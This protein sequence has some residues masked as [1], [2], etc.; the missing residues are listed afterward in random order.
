MP[1]TT[2][3]QSFM[4]NGS[5]YP[6]RFVSLDTS[7][8]YKVIQS[9][10]NLAILGISQVGTKDP[11]GVS[12]SDGYAA[13]AGD[14]I[15][16]FLAGSRTLLTLPAA[17]CTAGDRLGPDNDGKGVVITPG[18]GTDYWVGALALATQSGAGDVQVEVIGPYQIGT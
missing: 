17:G 6:C 15:Q 18:A 12:G 7:A 4:A 5:I 14:Q 1:L 8:S 16:V 11:P 3:S 9:T 2:F 10:S 13:D